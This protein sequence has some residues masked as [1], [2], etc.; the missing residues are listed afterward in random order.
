MAHSGPAA[1]CK[2]SSAVQGTADTR[3]NILI[4][5]VGTIVATRGRGVT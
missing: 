3:G 4:D 1:A 5:A 2:H